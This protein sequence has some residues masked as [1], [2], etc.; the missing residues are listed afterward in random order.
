MKI[1]SVWAVKGTKP[2]IL[3]TGSHKKIVWSGALAENGTQLFRT[4]K[5]ADSNAFLDYLH[6]L[7]K[8]YPK[9]ILFIDKAP[10]H[11]EKRINRF[12]RKNKKTIKIKWFPS[13]NP[14]A[15]PMEECWKQGKTE[16]LGSIFYHSFQDFKKATT[17]YYRT[18]R[19]KLDLYKYLCH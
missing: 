5:T 3:T 13:G 1:R 18:K 17:I 2:K 14:E 8:K 12:F 6:H 10:W 7:H 19:F 9:M 11:R 16:V 4:Y 15:N